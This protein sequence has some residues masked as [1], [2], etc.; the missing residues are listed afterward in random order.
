MNR[1]I[2]IEAFDAETCKAWGR[3]AHK[4][5][6]PPLDLLAAQSKASLAHLA[7][8]RH[9]QE[10]MQRLDLYRS[11]LHQ[12]TP[13]AK[14]MAKD[15]GEICRLNSPSLVLDEESG[16]FLNPP[17]VLILETNGDYVRV[18]QIHDEPELALE[19]DVPLPDPNGAYFVESW[20]T[21]P[22]LKA[23]LGSAVAKVSGDFVEKIKRMEEDPFSHPPEASPYEAFQALEARVGSTFCQETLGT[24]FDREQTTRFTDISNHAN[25][26]KSQAG[27]FGMACGVTDFPLGRPG[28]LAT[29]GMAA[30]AGL[31]EFHDS[32]TGASVIIQGNKATLTAGLRPVSI[33]FRDENNSLIK[34][35]GNTE[36]GLAPQDSKP[37]TLPSDPD[38]LTPFFN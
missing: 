29:Y 38:K 1:M 24:L 12:L 11:M 26:H 19:G 15:P 36:I 14:P 13:T 32:Q 28:K 4:R 10:K 34:I 31:K 33:S 35:C 23:S 25:E 18:A 3:M 27:S 22:I 9:C 8:C 21:Y 17:L 37:V 2:N 30:D 20:N 6:C 5:G 7:H 16:N